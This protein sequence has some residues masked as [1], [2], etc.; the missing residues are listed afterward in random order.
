VDDDVRSAR[1]DRKRRRASHKLDCQNHK[2][3]IHDPHFE[4][5]QLEQLGDAQRVRLVVA[6]ETPR[7]LVGDS[8]TLVTT[9][10]N[11]TGYRLDLRIN[12]VTDA[13]LDWFMSRLRSG[14]LPSPLTLQFFPNIKE[15]TES[16]ATL[17]LLRLRVDLTL[18]TLVLDVGAGSSPRT[19]GLIAFEYPAANVHSIDPAMR[20]DWTQQT[21][22]SNLRAHDCTI[23]DWI[24]RHRSMIAASSRLAIVA[25]HSHAR[26]ENYLPIL[27]YGTE[28][29]LT[30][31]TVPCCFEQTLT[32][33]Q[34][35]A[36]NLYSTF[37][38]TDWGIHSAKR[39]MHIW[40]RKPPE[41]SPEPS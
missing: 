30:V 28:R 18:P 22:A 15:V 41:E 36:L 4:T 24:A 32:G 1:E 3:A 29:P 23:E 6:P 21:I 19:G 20:E 40:T 11:K 26:L 17:N 38:T 10:H 34:Q 33:A 8:W 7:Q 14:R 2:R 27:G 13:H 37:S 31:L 25:V 39:T 35:D 16:V 5:V 12:S 9:R